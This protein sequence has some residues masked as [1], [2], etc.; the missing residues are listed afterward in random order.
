[1]IS[2]RFDVIPMHLLDQLDHSLYVF[3]V[4]VVV[5]TVTG[6]ACDVVFGVGVVVLTVTGWDDVVTTSVTTS[7][8]TTM[9]KTHIPSGKRF[10]L[11][12]FYFFCF[13]GLHSFIGVVFSSVLSIHNK[14]QTD[15]VRRL[16]PVGKLF[17]N[18]FLL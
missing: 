7:T 3:G 15:C 5:L 11:F 1:M 14:E 13:Q 10:F 8:E 6:I 18:K 2:T 17:P 9:S 12:I 16:E 4:G